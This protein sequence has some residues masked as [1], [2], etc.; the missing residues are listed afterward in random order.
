MAPSTASLLPTPT[1]SS[2]RRLSAEKPGLGSRVRSL[3]AGRL[4]HLRNSLGTRW[5]LQGWAGGAGPGFSLP[6][7]LS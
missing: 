2:V 1:P 7:T 3:R 5:T 4:R 6:L